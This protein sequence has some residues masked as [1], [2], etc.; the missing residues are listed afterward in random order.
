MMNKFIGESVRNSN[1]VE[2]QA[3]DF[4]QLLGWIENPLNKIK[5]SAYKNSILLSGKTFDFKED[6]KKH[7]NAV[8]NKT[9]KGWLVFSSN[10]NFES[11]KAFIK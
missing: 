1:E 6:F 5:V 11:L 8:F 9:L 4:N 3:N 2:A 10:E 7:F